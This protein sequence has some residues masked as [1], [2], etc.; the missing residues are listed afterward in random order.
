MPVY[1]QLKLF[2]GVGLLSNAISADLPP[3]GIYLDY[4]AS[5]PV[6]P[7][8]LEAMLPWWQ[9]HPGNPHSEEHSFGWR[10][11]EA[12]EIARSQIAALIRVDAEDIVF[13]SGATEANNLAILGVMRY[14]ERRRNTLLVTA[15]EH[16][17]VLGPA[18]ELAREGIR[19]VILPVD[20]DGALN[21]EAFLREL[22]DDVLL[23]SVGAVNGEI[24]TIQDISWIAAHCREVGALF[25]T[26]AAQAL[27]SVPQLLGESGVDLVSLSAH[28]AYGPI[29][30]G[31]LYVA[32]GIAMRMKRLTFGGGQQLGL[33]PGTLPTA[34]C[35]G[36]GRAC[37]LL[38]LIGTEERERVAKIRDR[39]AAAILAQVPGAAINGSVTRR[40]PGNINVQLPGADA[41]DVIQRMQPGLAVST[42][43][44]CHSG[45]NQSSHVLRAIG[46]NDKAAFSSVRIGLGRFTTPDEPDLA[47]SALMK[48]LEGT[49]SSADGSAAALADV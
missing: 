47:L 42:G 38:R 21:R 9:R 37:E 17:S 24:G 29:G 4:H 35:V 6:D 8:V 32:P 23:V 36:F 39:L 11:N 46:L 20:S 27:T 28:K 13:T 12:I 43:S 26:D 15:I 25:H 14:R 7:V 3:G 49:R 5:T 41:R 48:A 30:I 18:D 40:H 45:E 10:A 1:S 2:Q 33:R 22:S 31:A 44:A 19:C 34:L 16:A